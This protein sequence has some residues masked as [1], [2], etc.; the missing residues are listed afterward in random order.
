MGLISR[1]S[2]R[3]YRKIMPAD[4]GR[5][6]NTH[7]K[8]WDKEKFKQMAETR[9]KAQPEPYKIWASQ[10]SHR[11]KHLD[12]NLDLLAKFGGRSQKEIIEARNAEQDAKD[13]AEFAKIRHERKN[14]SGNQ[15]ANIRGRDEPVQSHMPASK[16]VAS[17]A[18]MYNFDFEGN[19]GT[20]GMAK[21]QNKTGGGPGA[22]YYCSVC[23][24]T[25]AD[26]QGWLGHLN[27]RRHQKNLGLSVFKHTKSTLAEVKA[28]I[29]ECIA[30]KNKVKETYNFDQKVREAEEE[31]N[32]LK[33][34]YKA[35][36][37]AR[38][39]KK[40]MEEQ[41]LVE[42]QANPADE[43]EDDPE[44]YEEHMDMQ[45]MMGFGGFNSKQAKFS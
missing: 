40:K 3:T 27:G 42:N 16:R 41:G 24:C 17:K 32:K 39:R 20:S 26:S 7:R 23:D 11:P 30:E 13:K 14:Q 19:V 2:S 5:K 1:V 9:V 34:K 33:E 29:A 15:T 36:K 38:K 37:K 35:D 44:A 43:F 8:T 4:H 25:L 21:N 18:R 10:K 22:G 6:D 28:V 45:A 31:M 12:Q